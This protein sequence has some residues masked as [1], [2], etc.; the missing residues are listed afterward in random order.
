[1]RNRQDGVKVP[2]TPN[3]VRK[4]VLD[5]DTAAELRSI[6]S[7]GPIMFGGER[8]LSTSGIQR[9]FN[10]GIKKSGVKKIRIHDLR[11]SHATNLIN[12]GV[13]IVSVSRRLGHSD[14]NMTL[15]VYTHLLE[16]T[17]LEMLD[18]ISKMKAPQGA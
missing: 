17:D 18:T 11:H 3:S 9:A 16:K 13:N 10:E 6:N 1:M 2:K 12:S 5:P 7:K 14:I 4:V 8:Y 15:K